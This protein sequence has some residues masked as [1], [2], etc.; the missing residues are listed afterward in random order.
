MEPEHKGIHPILTIKEKGREGRQKIK[1][2]VIRRKDD[3]LTALEKNWRDWALWPLTT[4]L[5][6]L[7]IRANH[8]TGAG[9]FLIA[10][11]IWMYFAGYP[12]SWQFALLAAIA[13]SDAIDG[14]A[15]RNND[16]VTVLGTWMD[17]IRDALLMMWASYLIFAYHLLSGEIIIIVW[18]L[19]LLFIY[20][21]IKDFLIRY[22]EMLSESE[23]RG[24]E[25][26][27]QFSL[28]N[29]QA[30]VI[31]RLQFFFWTVSYGSLFLSL[32]FPNA[33]FSMIGQALIILEIIFAALNISDTYQKKL[34]VV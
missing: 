22:L 6:K 8:I 24:Q 3:M 9:F 30:S 13:V 34:D 16:D 19:E 4:V 26:M 18:S 25:L 17:H 1:K 29:L 28:D 32:Y 27:D 2:I 7:K 12:F 11:A 20:A 15:A 23:E 14:P 31:G 21:S 33:G 10:F 5:W